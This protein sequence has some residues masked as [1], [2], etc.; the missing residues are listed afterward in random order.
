MLRLARRALP[1][2]V[3]FVLV[4]QGAAFAASVSIVDFAFQ[5][6]STSLGLGGSVTWT[7]NGSVT[8]TTTDN[9]VDSTSGPTLWNSG[10]L[11]PGATFSFAFKGAGKFAYHCHIHQ[12]MTGTVTVPPK[13]QPRTGTTTTVFTITWAVTSVPSG[14]NEDIQIMRPTSTSWVAWKSNKTGTSI[15]ATFTPDAGTG[16]YLFR[17]R[18]QNSTTNGASAYSR[19][20]ISVS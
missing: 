13:A 7:N 16:T 15:S 18:L 2:A 3:L 14:F 12:S 17:A 4:G 1:L 10:N 11:S 6:S 19:M 5:P 9:G 20:S 8:H